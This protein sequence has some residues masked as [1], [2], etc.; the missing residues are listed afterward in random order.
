M[1]S[2]RIQKESTETTVSCSTPIS[3]YY[4][5]K[6]IIILRFLLS[7][8]IL[9]TFNLD[10]PSCKR[11][12]RRFFNPKM[13]VCTDSSTNSAICYGDSGKIEQ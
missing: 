7:C 4:F 13:M 5:K 6:D 12:Y 3:G 8:N 2:G 1:G 9:F 10:E 11:H